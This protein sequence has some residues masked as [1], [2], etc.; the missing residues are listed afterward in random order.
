MM[1]RSLVVPDLRMQRIA[2][3]RA[4]FA[5]HNRLVALVAVLTL[6]VTA[7]IWYLLFAVL[8]WLAFLFASIVRGADARPPEVLPALFIYSAGLLVLLAWLARKRFANEL[9]K[10]EK[11]PWEIAVEFLLA[12][13]RATI[14]VWGNV[15]AWQRLDERELGLATD[16]IGTIESAG[17]I[18]LHQVPLDI[19][20][21]RDRL[22]ILL[23]LQLI[24]VINVMPVEQTMW[25]SLRSKNGSLVA[26]HGG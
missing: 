19:P 22:R 24:E 20:D 2:W 5:E 25:L 26:S 12:I 9:P 17:R 18:P 4:K 6:L 16:L 11:S 10:D 14:A 3:L 1:S 8:Y 23:A 21:P 15:S 7:G 13:P